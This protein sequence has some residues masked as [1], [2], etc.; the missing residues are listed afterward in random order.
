[1]ASPFKALEARVNSAVLS[2]LANADA[3][4]TTQYGEVVGFSVIFDAPF[5]EAGGFEAEQPSAL[6]RSADV[7]GLLHGS[8]VYIGDAAWVVAGLQPDGA[9]M[10]RIVLERAA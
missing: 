2:R 6:A 1:M 3:T 10:T 4:A 8:Q 5:Q 9:G 7:A